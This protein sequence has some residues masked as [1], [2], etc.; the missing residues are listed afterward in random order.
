MAHDLDANE[1]PGTANV[2]DRLMPLC[3]ALEFSFQIG[4]NLP[5]IRDQLVPLNHVEHGVRGGAGYS[6]PSES[7]EVTC[8]AAKLLDNLGP[9]HD[10]GDRLAVAV[11]LV[12]GDNALCVCASFDDGHRAWFSP[13]YFIKKNNA[14][15]L[16]ARDAGWAKGTQ[17]YDWSIGTIFANSLGAN[18]IVGCSEAKSTCNCAWTQL[19]DCAT[20]SRMNTIAHLY[21][22]PIKGLSPESLASATL[23]RANGL[24]FDREYALALGTTQFDE[25]NP[26]P[27]DKG[28]FL[29]LRSNE[30]LAALS[31]RFD[32][33]S[34]E[35]QIEDQTGRVVRGNLTQGDGRRM[36]ENFFLDY[37]GVATKG[38]PK[39]VQA[40]GH[41]FTD[42]SVMSPALM[43]AV[44]VINLAS[45]EALAT[46]IRTQIDPLRFRGNVYIAGLEPWEELSW[47]DREVTIGSVRLRG[48]ARTPR[49]AAVNVNPD[50]AQRDMNLPKA[51]MQHFGH[52]DL[53]AYLEVLDDGEVSVGDMLKS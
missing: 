3:Q 9:H 41:K 34:N 6:V 44:S 26:V 39:V 1:K 46:A 51:I 16:I 14:G 4:P 12:E 13:I 52:T 24:P 20:H 37:L 25:D 18:L 36:I 53:G 38:Q 22:Y 5:C 42:A 19:Q 29:M 7:V 17:D 28:Y 48:L 47:V 2:A 27:L 15:I 10:A 32:I 49:C 50:T 30:Q 43:R 8:L 21:R 23:T 31:T 40:S 35:L 45:L 11:E 33:P